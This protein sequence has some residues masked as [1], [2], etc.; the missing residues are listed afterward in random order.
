MDNGKIWDNVV[1]L[2]KTGITYREKHSFGHHSYK[3]IL[4]TQVYNYRKSYYF[5]Q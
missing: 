5:Y 3:V 1:L 2:S 4:Q